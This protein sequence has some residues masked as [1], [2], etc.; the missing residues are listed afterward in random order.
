MPR[1]S[2]RTP[3]CAGRPETP[4][5][6]ATPPPSSPLT[7]RLA[8]NAAFAATFRTGTTLTWIDANGQPSVPTHGGVALAM[9]T[10]AASD[11]GVDRLDWVMNPSKLAGVATAWDTRPA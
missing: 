10:A 11:A 7:T 8:L 5:P 3:G 1:T 4:P 9:L 2:C 6:C